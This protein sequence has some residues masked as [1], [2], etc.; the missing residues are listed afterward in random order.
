MEIRSNGYGS[1]S[2]VHIHCCLLA[3]DCW[4]ILRTIGAAWVRGGEVQKQ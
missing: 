2:L 4:Y 1:L 3:W